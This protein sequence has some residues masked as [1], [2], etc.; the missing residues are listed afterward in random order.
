MKYGE[1]VYMINWLGKFRFIFPA[2]NDKKK[3]LKV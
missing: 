2:Y 1:F 3:L